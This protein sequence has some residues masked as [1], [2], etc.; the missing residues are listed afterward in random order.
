[1]PDRRL[2]RRPHRQ[3]RSHFGLVQAV[4]VSNLA[5][6]S[7]TC[8]CITGC[9]CPSTVTLPSSVTVDLEFTDCCGFTRQASVIASLGA[10]CPAC[11]PCNKYIW[12][13]ADGPVVC[14]TGCVA[15]LIPWGC[16]SDEDCTETEAIIGQVAISADGCL[17]AGEFEGEPTGVCT[18]WMMTITVTARSPG[19]STGPHQQNFGGFC[20]CVWSQGCVVSWNCFGGA[21]TI[22]KSDG[23]AD[24]RGTYETCVGKPTEF[25]DFNESACYNGGPN[26]PAPTVIVS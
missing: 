15:D 7:C 9:E 19:A 26:L 12:R 22:C 20:R 11:L 18:N 16:P 3:P 17:Y 5:T 24:P 14:N 1:M 4:S 13:P 25:C 8:C 23:T 21:W 10:E 2:H 6:S